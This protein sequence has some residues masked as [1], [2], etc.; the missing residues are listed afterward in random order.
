MNPEVVTAFGRLRG[1]LESGLA[2]FRGIRFA[3]TT[4]GDGRFRPPRRPQ[5]WDGVRDALAFGPAAPQAQPQLQRASVFQGMFGAGEQEMSEDCLFLNVWTPAPDSD[6]RPVMVWVHGGGFRTGSGS[7]PMYDGANLARRGD[8]VV[9]SINYRLGALGFLYLPE[10]DGANAGHLDQ[11]KA[12]EWVRE[13]I[14][15]FGGDP[16]NVTIFGE[17]AG[18][19]SVECLLATPWGR[20]LFHK[21]IAQSTYDP[22]MDT[23]SAVAAAEALLGQLGLERGAVETLRSLPCAE[24]LQAQVRLQEQAMAGGPGLNARTGLI[25][26]IDGDVLPKHPLEAVAAGAVRE[27]PTL[28]GTNLDEAKLFGAMMP[29]FA[30]I[31]EAGLVQR[32]RNTVPGADKDGSIAHR[33]VDAYRKAREARRE[34]AGPA[35]LWFA[36][37]TDRT[38]HQH[39]IRLA[40]AQSRHQA[41]TYM[42]LFTWASPSFEGALGSCHALELPFMF[43]NMTGPLANL[44]GDGPEARALSDKMMD[45][46]LAFARTGD[47]N[48]PSLPPW[49]RYE[50]SKRG[51]MLLGAEC[52]PESA[53]QEDAR[54]F[55]ASLPTT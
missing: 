24:V 42:Y 18:G 10:L 51:T 49:P 23:E 43:G 53:P 11:V 12:L 48:P 7:S 17:S 47:P 30:Q 9:V 15:A 16:D 39:S 21:A 27:V 3:A 41:A 54:R 28:V 32:L 26:V 4:A 45:A 34:P 13:N 6:R 8:V 46:W 36:I 20:G 19:K 38:F 33:A 2:V 40:E 50:A 1:S 22:A 29:G 52:K 37:S 5:P 44:A 35:D 25:P 31:D 14:S 55:W